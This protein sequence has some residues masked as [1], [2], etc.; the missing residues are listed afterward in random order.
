[1]INRALGLPVQRWHAGGDWGACN[2]GNGMTQATCGS[3][4][5]VAVLGLSLAT[6]STARRPMI[7]GLL[8]L[9]VQRWHAGGDWGAANDGNG[10]L[11]PR[12]GL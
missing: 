5:T 12:A 6:T 1:M 9:P 8:C 11:R 10:I 4:S 2:D 3:M 7:I